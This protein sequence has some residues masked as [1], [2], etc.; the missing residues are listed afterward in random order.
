[1]GKGKNKISKRARNLRNEIYQ[2]MRAKQKS[3]IKENEKI[4]LHKPID[5]L[6]PAEQRLALEVKNKYNLNI[7]QIADEDKVV[8]IDDQVYFAPLGKGVL[9]EI[10]DCSQPAY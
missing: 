3:Q 9:C 2:Q 5:H 8:I 4:Y 6:T 10:K 1:M 7:S